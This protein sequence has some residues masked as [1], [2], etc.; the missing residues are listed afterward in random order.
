MKASIIFSAMCVLTVSLPSFAQ[1]DAN[2]GYSGLP[3]NAPEINNSGMSNAP[4][5]VPANGNFGG[6][7]RHGRRGMMPGGPGPSSQNAPGQIGAGNNPV[8]GADMGRPQGLNGAAAVPSDADRAARREAHRRRMMQ[9]FDLNGDGSLDASEQAKFE[10]FKQ[11]RRQQRGMGRGFGGKRQG[12]QNM[13]APGMP[14]SG[15]AP[16]GSSR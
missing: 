4:A 5:G 8:P 14:S 3:A 11:E 15:G 2:S 6:R 7:R 12:G 1:P 9:R 10:A 13:P 16:G